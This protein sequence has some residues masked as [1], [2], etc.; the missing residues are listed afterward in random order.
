[1]GKYFTNIEK[2]EI[3]DDAWFKWRDELKEAN[4][5][6]TFVG[7][8]DGSKKV[9]YEGY[10]LKKFKGFK[11]IIPGKYGNNFVENVSLLKSISEKDKGES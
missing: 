7:E 3:V 6:K 11:P 9:M 2:V 8:N 1:M 4:K 5:G 10:G